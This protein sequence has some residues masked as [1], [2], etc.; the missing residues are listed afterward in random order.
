M[1][2]GINFPLDNGVILWY[3][4]PSRVAQLVEQTAVNRKVVGLSP[5][6]GA[7]FVNKMGINRGICHQVLP[8]M[9]FS[10]PGMLIIGSDS[11]TTTYGAFNCLSTGVGATDVSV[12][13]ATGKQ[14]FK[15]PKSYKIQLKN[16]LNI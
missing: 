15:V 14:W 10:R 9:G 13:F 4:T 5:T 2:R 6:R 12:T 7:K 8:E 16:Q 1:L 11:H 3:N